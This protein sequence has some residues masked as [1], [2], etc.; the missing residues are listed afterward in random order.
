MIATQRSTSASRSGRMVTPQISPARGVSPAAGPQ[1][2][3]VA[4]LNENVS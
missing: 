4:G 2:A 3:A 1:E